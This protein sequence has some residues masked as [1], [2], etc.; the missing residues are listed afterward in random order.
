MKNLIQEIPTGEQA[1][2]LVKNI[3]PSG[4]N[5]T[6]TKEQL[7]AEMIES[8]RTHGVI[9]PLDCPAHRLR[10]NEKHRKA[11][12]GAS[13]V[14]VAGERRWLSARPSGVKKSKSSFGN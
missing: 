2:L 6:V 13:H 9:E 7:D 3:A 1:I 10:E 5:R 11:A 12:G 8:V 14:L 4:T